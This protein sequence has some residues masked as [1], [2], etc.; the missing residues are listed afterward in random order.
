MKKFRW[1]YI[2]KV[3]L[4][5]TLV[6]LVAVDLGGAWLFVSGLTGGPCDSFPDPPAAWGSYIDS[7]ITT[8]DSRQ[9]P[10]RYYP[11]QNG[12]AV[13]AMGGMGGSIGNALPYVQ[14]LLEAGYGVL[15][16]GSRRCAQ[17]RGKVTL[18]YYEATD[19]AQGL[20]YLLNQPEID[21][22]RIGIYGFSMGGASAIRAAARNPQIMAVVAMGGYHNL[23]EDFVEGDRET[24][25]G[26]PKWI[27]YHTITAT[28]RL[29]TGIDPWQSS[30][31]DDLPAISPR[32]V[33]LIYGE[34]EVTTNRGREQYAAALEPK[35]LWVVPGAGH[36]DYH[37]AAPEE[38]ARRLVEFFDAALLGQ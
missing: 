14:P 2:L 35:Q 16:V 32:P 26:L 34:N 33:L 15:Q 5:T 6:T 20:T 11:S 4:F 38:F 23:G 29:Q 12:A 31:I 28:Y 7:T 10:V 24:R 18:G 1:Q 36:G 19:A 37:L 8:H 27:F 3:V 22:E 13:I 21:P 30:P 25:L 9:L 17:P